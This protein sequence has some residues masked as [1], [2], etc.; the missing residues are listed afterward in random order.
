MAASLQAYR[1]ANYARERSIPERGIAS[2]TNGKGRSNS[3]EATMSDRTEFGLPRT[4]CACKVCVTNCKHMPGFLIP[5]DLDR[6]IPADLLGFWP[7]ESWFAERYLLASPGAVAIRDGK[8]YRVRTLVPAVKPSGECVHL[9]GE[10]CGIHTISPFG[11]AFF[12]CGPE[13]DNLSLK[14]IE[15]VFFAW[16]DETSLY[17][18]IW[19]HLSMLDLVQQSPEVLRHRM[20]G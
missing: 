9:N 2:A 16:D 3:M 18:R 14:G 20:Q 8:I 4:T 17:C 1:H 19:T 6:I 7:G 15:A 5:A 13:R 10:Q 12:D 11:C